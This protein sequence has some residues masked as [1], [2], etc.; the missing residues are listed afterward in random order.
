MTI[1]VEGTASVAG[2]VKVHELLMPAYAFLRR[3]PLIH[4]D[5]DGEMSHLGPLVTVVDY[6]D[7]ESAPDVIRVTVW[8]LARQEEAPE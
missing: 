5:P 1:T 4:A 6:P 8:Q 3:V 2:A 7:R